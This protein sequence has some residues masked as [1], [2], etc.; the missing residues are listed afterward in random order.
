MKTSKIKILILIFI[1]SS[2]ILL[3]AQDVDKIIS[4][5]IKAHGGEKNWSAVNSMKITGEFTAF[6]VV[7]DFTFI[8]TKT[9]YYAE[10]YLGQHKVTEAFNGETG[11]TIDPWQEIEYARK[12]NASE[13]NVFL[14]KNEFCTP[15]FYY[16]KKGH[17]VEY[18]GKEKVDGIEVYILKLTRANENV[19]TWYLNAKTY[20][21]Y[22]CESMWIDFAWASPAETYFEDFQKVDGIIIPF[23]VERIFSQRNRIVKIKNVEINPTIDQSIFEMPK[24]EE[25]LKLES[26]VGEWNVAVELWTRRGTWYPIDN[27]TSNFEFAGTNMIQENISYERMFPISIIS[28][29]TY[30]SKTKRYRTSIF[31]DFNSSISILEGDFSEDS[32]ILDDIKISFGD[33]NDDERV[34]TQ[35]SFTNIEKDAF[36]MEF[37]TS[38]DNGTTW[39]PRDRFSYTRK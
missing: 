15:F 27:T 18:V 32:F 7:E 19:E 28:N 26:F 13:E 22:K 31:N 35:L 25:I 11:W 1:F 29:M 12:I 23:Y 37:K 5:H 14:Q 34:F 4:K 3:L 39:Q 17:I 20:L 6:S 9:N 21:E 33:E 8:K 24:T 38:T 10:Q 2:P 36:I 16:K 30:D